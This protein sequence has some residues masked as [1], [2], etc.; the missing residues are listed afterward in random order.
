MNDALN[1]THTDDTALDI[2][3]E[4][5]DISPAHLELLR[6]DKA[7][8]RRCREMM[9][10]RAAL[11]MAALHT[12][13][14][15]KLRAFHRR[16]SPRRTHLLRTVVALGTA[17]ALVAV[18]FLLPWKASQPARPS[19]TATASLS[20]H[21]A[22]T[23]AHTTGATR[24]EAVNATETVSLS[25]YRKILTEGADVERFVADVPA[26]HSANITLPDGSRVWLHPG[27]RL[28]YPKEFIGDKRFVMLDGEA[29]FQVTK[30]PDRP[31]I[32]QSG[33]ITTTVLGTEFNIK[34]DVVTLI[35]GSVRVAD[36]DSQAT[37]TLSPGEQATPA[38]GH[39]RVDDVD[40][41]PYVYWRDGYLYYDNME[42]GEIVKAIGT[43]YGLPVT[44]CESPALR[45]RI[46][47]IAERDKGVDTVLQRLDRMQKVHVYRHGGR[48]IVE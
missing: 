47:F 13:V 2:L 33:H 46:R 29:D 5:E 45:Q 26:G 24:H 41:L 18:A 4:G 23:P 38:G 14:E 44:L 19:Q 21:K 36:T 27:S 10:D 43:V 11:R 28:R 25:D 34:G 12:D 17:A 9:A 20:P 31:F 22:H 32:V 48:I 30:A 7:L 37:L 40:T 3:E 6:K 42:I 8:R 35:R 39:F 15:G 16:H 1:T